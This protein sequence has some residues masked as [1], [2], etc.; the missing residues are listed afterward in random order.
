MVNYGIVMII[1]ANMTAYEAII[2]QLLY[3][4]LSNAIYGINLFSQCNSSSKTGLPIGYSVTVVGLLIGED[5]G[6]TLSGWN[7]LN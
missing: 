3:L 4:N 7:Q 5:N 1:T 6:V 2:V